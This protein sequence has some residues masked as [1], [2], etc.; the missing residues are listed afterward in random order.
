MCSATCAPCWSASWT[1]EI[2]PTVI[3]THRLPLDEAPHGYEMFKH[4]EDD[5]V[6]V[7]LKPGEQKESA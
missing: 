2:D 5:C 6:K 7:V 4:K 3:I 1:G